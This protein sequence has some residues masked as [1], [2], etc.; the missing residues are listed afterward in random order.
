MKNLILKLEHVFKVL[1]ALALLTGIG[2]S[3]ASA[4]EVTLSV[5]HLPIDQLYVGD[6]DFQTGASQSWFFT[7][8]IIS[9]TPNK[10]VSLNLTVD[11]QLSDASFPTAITLETDTFRVDGSRTFTNLD[12]G[13]SSDI[14]I[15]PGTDV[16][17]TDAARTRI[18]DE[19]LATGKLPAGTYTFN[20]EIP[21][22]SPLEEEQFV[23]TIRNI[24]RL[25]LI[26]PRDYEEVPNP[27]PLFQWLYEGNIVE[28]SVYE[29]LPQH[30]SKEEAAQG[31]PHY[32]SPL[33]GVSSLQY[34]SAGV[35]PIE[36]G[37]AYVWKV[38]GLT[39][40]SGGQ[41]ATIN[42]E[43]W[44]F[45]VASGGGTLGAEG[46]TAA[47]SIQSMDLINLIQQIPGVSPELTNQLLS[48]N[49][50]I[51]SPV[52]DELLRI[53]NDLVQNPD[54]IIGVQTT[55]AAD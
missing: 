10:L 44:Q 33:A 31:V 48:G 32:I 35:R 36:P 25:D 54:K 4:Q 46:A 2:S 29:R 39:E 3:S 1:T 13:T 30:Q 23:L 6:L 17:F 16:Q 14:R 52:T 24:S 7:V 43:I 45:T 55:T 34:P 5:V 47:S 28:L 49:L 38:L 12:I 26:S 27:F 11:I 37:K 40:G 42:S 22:T 20:L 21:G 8:S 19:A 51:V 15:K 41:S 18:Q 9:T 53:L 50:Q